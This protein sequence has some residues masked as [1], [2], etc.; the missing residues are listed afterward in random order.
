[1]SIGGGLVYLL[2]R[3]NEADHKFEEKL[4]RKSL[5]RLAEV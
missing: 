5:Y 1:M 4:G 3:H 2:E